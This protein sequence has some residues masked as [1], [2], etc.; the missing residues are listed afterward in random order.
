M[1]IF[2]IEKTP[3]ISIIRKN[4][5]KFYKKLREITAKSV[6]VFIYEMTSLTSS[7]VTDVTIHGLGGETAC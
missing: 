4:N 7:A 2:Y 5:K 6:G 1:M 3:S